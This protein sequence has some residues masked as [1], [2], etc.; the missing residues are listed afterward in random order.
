MLVRWIFFSTLAFERVNSTT[1][2]E[3]SGTNAGCDFF[4]CTRRRYMRCTRLPFRSV[5]Y[6][7]IVICV[8]SL[9]Y[10]MSAPHSQAYTVTYT[11]QTFRT[12]AAVHACMYIA[13]QP[14]NIVTTPWLATHTFILLLPGF[15]GSTYER[16]CIYLVIFFLFLFWVVR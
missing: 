16:T 11:V 6:A 4:L 14:D 10:T 1:D 8:T 12:S 13:P 5:L 7:R 2:W 15:L 3:C 9:R